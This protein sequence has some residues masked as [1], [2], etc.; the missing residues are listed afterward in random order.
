M[1][2]KIHE[3]IARLR[4]EKGVTQE[5]FAK[6]FGV[7]NQAV[8]KWESGICCPDI[9]LLPEIADYFEISIDELMGHETPPKK[10]QNVHSIPIPQVNDALLEKAVKLAQDN[11]GK[12]STAYLQRHLSIGY[13][14]ARYLLN[15]LEEMGVIT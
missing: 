6:V 8:S 1:N 5:E 7:S 15:K 9:N 4:R 14:K 12:I 2:I 11:Y 10:V 3:Q 13:G